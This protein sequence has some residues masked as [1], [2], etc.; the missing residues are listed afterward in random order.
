[1]ETEVERKCVENNDEEM[2]DTRA[3]FFVENNHYLDVARMLIE[4]ARKENV[5]EKKISFRGYELT[6]QKEK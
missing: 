4:K 3:W 1:M 6:I 5:I 2:Q